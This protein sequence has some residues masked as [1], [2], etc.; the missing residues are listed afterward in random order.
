MITA[1]A[2]LCVC[3]KLTYYLHFLVN[4]FTKRVPFP[5]TPFY[6]S[7]VWVTIFGVPYVVL[8]TFDGS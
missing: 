8:I 2:K 3:F 5:V 4:I 1:V 7:S 6:L